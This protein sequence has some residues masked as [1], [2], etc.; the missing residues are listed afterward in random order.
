MKILKEI[1][2]HYEPVSV[3]DYTEIN[4]VKIKSY[5]EVVC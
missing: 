2:K 4:Y 1:S 5:I 3:A